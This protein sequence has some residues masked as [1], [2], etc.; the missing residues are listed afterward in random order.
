M[1]DLSQLVIPVLVDDEIVMRTYNIAGSGGSSTP[2]AMGFGYGTCSTAYA[3]TAKTATLTD[4]TLK[5][6]GIVAVKFVNNVNAGATLNINDEGA[7]PIYY[8][9]VPIVAGIIDSGDIATFVY[10]GTNYILIA[11]DSSSWKAD[12]V[13][14]GDENAVIT[15]TNSTY[16]IS[17]T[18]ALDANGY[19]VYVCKAPGT[20]VFD[21]SE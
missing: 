2:E 18:V 7:K 19:G 13:I 6:N 14:T 9:D 4:Y 10:D 5:T 1:A 20:Y 11:I 12:V 15:V 16:G 17:H 3:T 21:V 8:R